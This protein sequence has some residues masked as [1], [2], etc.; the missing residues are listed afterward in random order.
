MLGMHT[1]GSCWRVEVVGVL[2]VVLRSF[3]LWVQC[4]CRLMYQGCVQRL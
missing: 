3:G 4:N 2:L 1:K